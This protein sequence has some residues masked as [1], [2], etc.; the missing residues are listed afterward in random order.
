MTQLVYDPD[1]ISSNAF[2]L[3][4]HYGI[5]DGGVFT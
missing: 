1:G 4:N 2:D 5:L 3:S